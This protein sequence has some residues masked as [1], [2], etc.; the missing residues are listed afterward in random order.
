MR[1][2]HRAGRDR[3]VS[4]LDSEEHW[5]ATDEEAEARYSVECTGGSDEFEALTPPARAV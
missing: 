2:P 3:T 4:T 5:P 1:A